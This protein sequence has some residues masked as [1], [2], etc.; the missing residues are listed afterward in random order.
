[1]KCTRRRGLGLTGGAANARQRAFSRLPYR[2]QTPCWGGIFWSGS[3]RNRSSDAIGLEKPY[4]NTVSGTN[5]TK[6][7][8]KNQGF[9][10]I[11][12]IENKA[13]KHDFCRSVCCTLNSVFTAQRSGFFLFGSRY[14]ALPAALNFF[15]STKSQSR[16][17]IPSC[18]SSQGVIFRA[19]LRVPPRSRSSK[20][21]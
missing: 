19:F 12:G 3:G 10:K 9:L 20:F 11:Q 1:M 4:R 2:A 5:S 16:R 6:G 17:S 15:S 8:Q 7:I 18:V 13:V 14:H 21:L